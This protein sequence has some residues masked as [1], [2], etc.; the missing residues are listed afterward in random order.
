LSHRI[1]RELLKQARLKAGLGQKGLSKK[2]KRS[3]NFVALVES[4]QRMLNSS[5]LMVYCQLVGTR[6]SKLLAV[7]ER[8]MRKH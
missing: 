2:L 8:R 3:E 5:E 6:A 4:G 7:V 1:T